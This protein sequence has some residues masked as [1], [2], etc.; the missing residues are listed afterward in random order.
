MI[1]AFV[2]VQNYSGDD[3]EAYLEKICLID[4]F[5]PIIKQYPEN[6]VRKG[7]ITYIALAYSIESDAI[8]MGM[9]WKRNKMLIFKRANLADS[10]WNDVGMLQEEAVLNSVN[11]WLNFQDSSTFVQLS[12]LRDL[13]T[14][15]QFS[16]NSK[17]LKSSGEVDYS[18][19][20]LNAGYAQELKKM[21]KD[22]ESEL[23]QNN[24]L[25][26][27]AVKEVKAVKIKN[28]MS[29]ESFAK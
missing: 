11:R 3:W 1:N 9:D 25:L 22:L 5:Q 4:I 18:Q 19:K 2:S 20:F 17:I 12:V 15:M 13:R 27:D 14:E 29:V 16:A 6:T 23:L 24:I 28:T 8:V 21:I 7:I 10:L 26:K